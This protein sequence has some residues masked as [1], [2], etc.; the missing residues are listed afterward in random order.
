MLFFF[1]GPHIID[2]FIK[3]DNP[4]IICHSLKLCEDTPGQ[5]KC[6]IYPSNKTD[7]VPQRALEL[8]QR[9][10]L[11]NEGLST[12]K[13]C[14]F[15]GIDEICKII[16]NIYSSHLPAVD[17]D[18]DKFGKE[19]TFRGGSWRGRDC[20]DISGTIRPGRQPIQGDATVDHNCNGIVGMN[21]PT[22]KSYE[23]GFCNV[24]K[25]LG[26]AVLGDSTSAHLHMPEQW[27]D[28]REFSEAA[29][30]HLPFILE[31]ELDWPDLSAITG[32]LNVSWP[33]IEGQ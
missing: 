9:H 23:D 32:H 20:N 22:G 25:R 33:N 16:E 18:H 12:P 27:F 19:T 24:S 14:S 2:G 26:V 30:E 4:D 28:A 11:I 7:S 6:R 5:P 17:A 10:P 31:D 1:Q 29:F 15:P 13:I 8:R 21:T 3:G